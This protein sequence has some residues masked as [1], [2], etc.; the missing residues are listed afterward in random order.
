MT[1]GRSVVYTVTMATETS[2]QTVLEFAAAYGDYLI[3][4]VRLL[5]PLVELPD[6]FPD[7]SDGSP[8]VQ[9]WLTLADAADGR[10]AVTAGNRFRVRDA[11][12]RL[13]MM[14]FAVPGEPP[15]FHPPFDWTDSPMAIIAWRAIVWALADEL[16]TIAEA[17]AL[18]G[19]TI[20][21][22][23]Q[24]KGLL[25]YRDPEAAQRQGQRLVNRNDILAINWRG[26]ETK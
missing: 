23:S 11:F 3:E 15:V 19:V 17:A 20:Q 16:I 14:L 21:A 8:L 9:E 12:R 5:S 18:A 2:R 4:R 10:L 26:E 24:R 25:F 7:P 13:A 1:P 6:V 22:V